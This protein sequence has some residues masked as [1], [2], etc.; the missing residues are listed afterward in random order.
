MRQLEGKAFVITGAASG[1]G[2]AIALECVRQG[3]S[4]AYTDVDGANLEQALEEARAVG[5]GQAIAIR[6]DVSREADVERIFDA[7]ADAFGPLDGAVANAGISGTPQDFLDLSL[8]EWEKVISVNLTSVFL[9]CRAAARL[10]VEQKRGGSI[11]A[12]GSSTAIRVHPGAIPYVASKSGIHGMMSALALSLAPHRIRVN[13]LVPGLTAT[14]AA[15]A[16]PGHVEKAS[17]DLPL[18]EPVTPQEL[19]RL[20][21]FVLSGAVPH[22]SG[23]LLK[24]DSGRTLG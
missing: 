22:M 11:I 9:T 8:D 10:L 21:A 16:L 19:G 14:P 15:L 5:R 17:K 23:T 20:V 18:G 24:I 2:R 4:I 3:A 12:T 1:I 13:T 7:A 6:A